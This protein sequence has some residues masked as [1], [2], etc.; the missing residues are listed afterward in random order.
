[1]L[2]ASVT[3]IHDGAFYGCKKLTSVV[4]PKGVTNIGPYAFESC[5]ALETVS[6]PS[7]LNTIGY[8]AFRYCKAITTIKS[9]SI[10]PFSVS[11]AFESSI[12]SNATV[13]VPT[14]YKEDYEDTPGWDKFQ[15]IV[16]SDEIEPDPED[17]VQRNGMAW[18]DVNDDGTVDVAD[19]STIISIMAA[20]ARRQE[21]ED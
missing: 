8:E 9:Y 20:K 11:N 4:I 1:M 3:K 18:G 7:S 10:D 16:E 13:Y 14:D 15:N 19:I 17:V 12:Y 21:V 5:E 2:S 6:L